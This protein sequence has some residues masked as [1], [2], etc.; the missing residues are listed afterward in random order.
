MNYKVIEC[1]ID[2]EFGVPQYG[3]VCE[4]DGIEILIIKNI[5]SRYDFVAKAAKIM[6]E[7]N[8]SVIHI[9]DYL[10]DILP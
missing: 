5:S 7:N 4:L 10:E 6:T 9:Y 1:K 3:I 2:D 8:L